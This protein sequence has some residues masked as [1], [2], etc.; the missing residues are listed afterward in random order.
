M[1]LEKEVIVKFFSPVSPFGQIN[2][3]LNVSKRN[4]LKVKGRI[5]SVVK[6][7]TPEI[8]IKVTP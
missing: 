3:R 5:E 4:T 7:L 6:K 8:F 1:I 2:I